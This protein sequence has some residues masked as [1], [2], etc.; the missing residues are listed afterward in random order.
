MAINKKL[1]SMAFSDTVRKGLVECK[2]VDALGYPLFGLT[3]KGEAFAK[4]LE[5]K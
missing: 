5:K 1:F 2:G 3:K 4:E